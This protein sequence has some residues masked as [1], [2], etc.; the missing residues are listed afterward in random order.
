M[1]QREVDPRLID[2]LG[3]QLERRD[4]TLQQGATRVGWKLGMGDRE[5][6]GDELAVGYLTSQTCLEPG[7]AHPATPDAALHADAE[8]ALLFGADVGVLMDPGTVRDTISGYG[9]A[10]EIVDLSYP[11]DDAESVVA[12]NVLH[13]AV[14]FGPVG[15]ALPE[16]ALGRLSI[17]GRTI[18]S[19]PVADDLVSRVQAAARVL[20]AVGERIQKGDRMITGSIVQVPIQPGDLVTAKI[21]QL[22]EVWLHISTS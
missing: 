14:S 3:S 5:R 9:V 18:D 21:D 16:E 12:T 22:G 8:V 20:D 11:P 13:R 15:S 7:S 1:T 4:A 10:L 19:A 17:D 2:A 6:I